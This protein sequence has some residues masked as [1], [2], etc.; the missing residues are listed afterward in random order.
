MRGAP[1]S[2]QE[3]RHGPLDVGLVVGLNM[4][5]AEGLRPLVAGETFRECAERRHHEHVDRGE[6][7]T[8]VEPPRLCVAQQHLETDVVET[9]L[10][11]RID[12]RAEQR[13]PD[14]P[15]ARLRPDVEVGDVRGLPAAIAEHAEDEADRAP[16]LLGHERDAVPVLLPRLLKLRGP[17]QLLLELLPQFAQEGALAVGGASDRHE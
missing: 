4:Q 14:A 9:R 1:E 6:A 8:F 15:P 16:V 11:R 7:E 12:Q 10:T 13:S 3:L 5:R 2:R 17:A